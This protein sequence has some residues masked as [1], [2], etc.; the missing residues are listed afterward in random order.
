MTFA[1]LRGRR[2]KR[3]PAPDRVCMTPGC[4]TKI[5]SWQWLCDACFKQLPFDRKKEICGAR[6]AKEGHRVFGLSRDAGEWLA[7]Q[8]E[9]RVGE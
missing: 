1:P 8:R 3:K 9:K 5:A 7:A 2:P 6:A 4:G